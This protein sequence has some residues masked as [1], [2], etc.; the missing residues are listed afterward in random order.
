[1][2]RRGLK[3]RIRSLEDQIR[4]HEEKIL[5]EKS[6]PIPDEDLINYW[7]REIQIFKE[8]INRANKRLR[9]GK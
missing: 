9:K 6:S 7:R 8:N 5:E 3:K 2:S 4:I 1:M